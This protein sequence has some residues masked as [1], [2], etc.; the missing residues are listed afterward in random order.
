MNVKNSIGVNEL[1]V[2]FVL[3]DRQVEVLHNFSVSFSKNKITGIIGESG[4]G[5]SVLGMAM[6]GILPPYAKVDRN[7]F[8]E[9]LYFKY[10]S[11]QQKLLLG[12]SLGYIPQSPQEALN[13]SRKIKKQLYEALSVKYK[14]NEFKQRAYSILEYMGFDNPNKIMNSYSYELSGGMQQRVLS[15]IS[16]CCKPKWIIADEPTKGLDKELCNQV[17]DTFVNLQEFGVEGMVV[18]THD[19]NLAEKICDEIL[20]MYGGRILERGEKVLKNPKH[21][22]TKALLGAMPE[23]FLEPIQDADIE[24]DRG[25]IFAPRCSSRMKCCLENSPIPVAVDSGYVECFLYE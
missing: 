2:D 1:K 3:P 18:I 4:S 21:P 11:K 9:D 16:V 23:Q 20:V 13:P 24:L 5:K 19:I 7:F 17:A 22:Y 15:A 6:L 12:K 25:C 10:K 14:K 8:F